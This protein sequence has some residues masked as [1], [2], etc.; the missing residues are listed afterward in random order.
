VNAQSWRT[1][2]DEELVAY[3]GEAM[4]LSV[5]GGLVS[6]RRHGTKAHLAVLGDVVILDADQADQIAHTFA[7]AAVLVRG[8]VE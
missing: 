4:D 5:T 3:H 2:D 1:Q 6:M 7:A 8:E